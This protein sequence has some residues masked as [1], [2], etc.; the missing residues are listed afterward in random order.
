MY[1]YIYKY[2]YMYV[3]IFT[4]THILIYT[5]VYINVYTWGVCVLVCLYIVCAQV[6]LFKHKHTKL[7]Q[8]LQVAVTAS[9][10]GNRLSD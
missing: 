8:Y 5:Y 4:H 3:C 7:Q 2:I 1:T 6:S 10:A 9:N